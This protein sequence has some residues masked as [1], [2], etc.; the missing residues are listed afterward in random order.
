MAKAAATESTVAPKDSALVLGDSPKR[1]IV[2]ESIGETDDRPWMFKG[3]MVKVVFPKNGDGSDGHR[4]YEPPD[5]IV[6]LPD[7]LYRA[8]DWRQTRRLL[9]HRQ[10]ML[11]KINAWVGVAAIGILAFIGFLIFAELYG[12]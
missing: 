7:K 10:T 11:D 1:R 8:L 4:G 9:A 3:R 2:V 5:R 6:M 12:V